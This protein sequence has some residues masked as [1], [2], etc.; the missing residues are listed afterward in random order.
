MKQMIMMKCM[1]LSEKYSLAFEYKYTDFKR[2]SAPSSSAD[3]F[4]TQSN[5]SLATVGS[6]SSAKFPRAFI[7]SIHF[8]RSP[9]PSSDPVKPVQNNHNPFLNLFTC[10]NQHINSYINLLR[11]FVTAIAF[12]CWGVSMHKNCSISFKH[13]IM[14]PSVQTMNEIHLFGVNIQNVYMCFICC[15][16][17]KPKTFAQMNVVLQVY[18]FFGQ[19][20]TDS[21]SIWRMCI[22]IYYINKVTVHLVIQF[23]FIREKRFLCF[24]KIH[25]FYLSK[26]NFNWIEFLV[27]R[28]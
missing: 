18:N 13:S 28:N 1:R 5:E 11:T 9:R 20:V 21:H 7:I 3:R 24:A 19:N 15:H 17:S 8:N 26:R 6:L 16:N 14:L 22:R 12:K 27:T 10:W 25:H 23:H 2:I 4:T